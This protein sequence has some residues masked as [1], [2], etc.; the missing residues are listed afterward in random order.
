[1][2]GVCDLSQM[3]VSAASSPPPPPP[4]LKV[5]FCPKAMHA[6]C[7]WLLVTPLCLTC[8]HASVEGREEGRDQLNSPESAHRP[9]GLNMGITGRQR[10]HFRSSGEMQLPLHDDAMLAIFG[11]PALLP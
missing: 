11:A 4:D 9:V 3:P 5:L 6:C 1:M 7:S 10:W 8:I 2:R